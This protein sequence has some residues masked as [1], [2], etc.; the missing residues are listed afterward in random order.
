MNTDFLIRKVKKMWHFFARNGLVFSVLVFCLIFSFAVKVFA[1]PPAT[2]YT[3]GETLNPSCAPGSANCVVGILPDQT[4][5][6]GKYLTTNG[7]TASWSSV[8]GGGI[9]I[10]TT[11][12][13]GGSSGGILFENGSGNVSE[14]T[15][16]TYQ[17]GTLSIKESTNPQLILGYDNG[18]IFTTRVSSNGNTNFSLTGTGPTF[19]FSN[20]VGIG[21]TSPTSNLQVNGTAPTFRITDNTGGTGSFYGHYGAGG[22]DVAQLA[23]NR[24]PSTG[25]FIN[26]SKAAAQISLN[27]ASSDSSI[28]FYTSTTNNAVPDLRMKILGNGNVGIGASTPSNLLHVLGTGTQVRIGYDTSSYSTYKVDSNANTEWK[29]VGGSTYSGNSFSVIGDNFYNTFIVGRYNN[30]GQYVTI[31]QASINTAMQIKT[32]YWTKDTDLTLGTYTTADSIHIKTNGNIGI[33]T[34]SPSRELDVIG[35]PIFQSKSIHGSFRMKPSSASYDTSSQVVD[36]YENF[37]PTS[38]GY[39]AFGVA[40]DIWGAPLFPSTFIMSTKN[41]ASTTKDMVFWSNDVPTANNA[42]LI[43]KANT[44]VVQLPTYGAG[45]HT[46]TPTQSL[47][48]DASGNIIESSGTPGTGTVVSVTAGTGL[49]GGTITT[50]GTIDLA[51]TAVAPG[52]YS[53]PSSIDVDQQGR[54]TGISNGTVVNQI[55]TSGPLT[56]SGSGNV[57]LSITQAGAGQDGYL[58]SG[59]WNTFNNKLSSL[60]LGVNQIGYGDGGGNLTSSA[61]LT[62]NGTVFDVNVSNITFSSL[63]SSGG[64]SYLCYDSTSKAVTYTMATCS[65]SSIRFKHDINNLTGNLDKV[66]ALRPVEYAYNKDNRRD[67]GFIAEEVF[68]IEPRLVTFEQDG[69]TIHGLNYAQFAPILAGAIQELDLKIQP[70]SSLDINTPNTLGSLIKSFLADSLNSIQNIFTNRLT[71]KEICVDDTTCLNE[72]DIRSLIENAH[73]QQTTVSTGGSNT[74]GDTNTGGEGSTNGDVNTTPTDEPTNTSDQTTNSGLG[75]STDSTLNTVDNTQTT[76]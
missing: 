60:S 3:P 65:V 46:G 11:A 41:G 54:I 47:M 52:N 68:N 75:T 23:I 34:N 25:V 28:L 58:S 22:Y 59:D 43:L 24:N 15:N 29:N 61:N 37:D 1:T 30:Q 56:G 66:M 10:N 17:T 38:S 42:S 21:T 62:F 64:D 50:S 44:G 27:S 32:N 69:T 2:S 8:A 16:L 20:Y 51:N 33:G 63:L 39:L 67:I 40:N 70:L 72:E 26:T 74:T 71:T 76:N 73:K 36:I 13:S 55:A 49:N 45:S 6:S 9:T 4:G 5:N 57:S 31:G 18:N 19:S 14:S 53:F 48:V 12:I 7:T 35:S